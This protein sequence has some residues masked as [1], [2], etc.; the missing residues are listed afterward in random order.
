[1]SLSSLLIGYRPVIDRDRRIMALQVRFAS[2]GEEPTRLSDLYR[3]MAGDRPLQSHTLLLSAPQAEF[4]AGLSDLEPTP[5]LWLEVP[6]TV[7]E[8]PEHQQMLLLLHDRGMGMVLQG[9]PATP[10]PEELLAVFR[11]AMVDVE[12]ERRGKESEPDMG[13]I[14]PRTRR[15]TAVVQS[16]VDSLPLMEQAFSMGAY[17]VCG[18]QIPP[19]VPSDS[20]VGSADYL[21]VLRLLAMVDRDASLR[22]IEAVV[23]QE[24]EIAFRLLQ[25]IDSMGFGLSVPVQNFQQAVMFMGYQ[26]LRRWLSLMLVSVSADESRRPLM[27]ASFRRGLILEQLVG[28]GADS[29]LREEMFLLGVFSLLDRALGQ[30]FSKLLAKVRVPDAVREALVEG[31]GSHVPLLRLVESIEQGPT[32]DVLAWLENSHLGLDACNRAIL[33][34]LRVV[35]V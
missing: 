4:D 27:L 16:G 23:R 28:H 2:L 17:A 19:L 11:L 34:T 1:M 21:G 22:E 24:P 26:G 31:S 8:D 10:L 5:G 30:P 32:P 3:L 29:E 33:A 18:W 7:A 6:A 25:H 14:R 9:T 15:N 35:E 13:L 20:A 12:D